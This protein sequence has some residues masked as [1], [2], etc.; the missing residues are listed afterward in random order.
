VTFDPSPCRRGLDLLLASC[1]HLDLIELSWQA[2]GPW[3]LVTL[4]QQSADGSDAFARH[5]YA[6]WRRT[7]A[8]HGVV[9]GAVT[10]D[11]VLTP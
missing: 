4:G 10:D 2:D 3:L 11:P 9:A 7:G 5:E 8:V 6:I 1:P